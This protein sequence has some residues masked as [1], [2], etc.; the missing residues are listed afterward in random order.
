MKVFVRSISKN[1]LLIIGV[2]IV[3]FI[4]YSQLKAHVEDK[5]V[6]NYISKRTSSVYLVN[7]KYRVDTAFI[8]NDLGKAKLIADLENQKLEQKRTVQEVPQFIWRFLDSI[9]LDKKFDI[10]SP[11]EEY[12][13]GITNFGHVIFKKV[14]DATK[15]DSVPMLSH[16]GAILPNKQ[17]VYFGIGK[18]IALMSYMSGGDPWSPG[19]NILIF[20]HNNNKITDLWFGG[21]WNGDKMDTKSDLLKSLK[22]KR[23]NNGC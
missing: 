15:K 21:M 17:L 9:S 23:E 4:A 2:V 22:T 20:K 5:T 12:K 3:S 11:G 10:V 1:P 19:A 14:W 6:I 18:D 8:R 13:E 16:D 7:G